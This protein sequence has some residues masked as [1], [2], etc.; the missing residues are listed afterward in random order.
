MERPAP[1][2]GIAGTS[3]AEHLRRLTQTLADV[4]NQLASPEA[5]A[6]PKRL[7]ELGRQHNDLRETIETARLLVSAESR[8]AQALEML[9]NEGDAELRELAEADRGEAAADAERLTRRLQSRLLP[10]DPYD[11]RGIMLEIRAGTG[12]EEA[13]LF[14]ADL[15]R[16]YMRFFEARGWAVEPVSQTD[17]EMGGF[18]E[19]IVNI[20]TPGA[21]SWLKFEG[22]TH[23][24]QRVPA[25]ETQGRI[26][27][28][29]A[30]VAVLPE[31]EETDVVIKDTD[32]RIDTMTSQG[33]GGQS[34]N[35]TYSAVRIVHLP[36]GMIVQC[37][38]ERS[39]LRN[40]ERAMQVLRARLMERQ[41]EADREA[42]SSMRKAMVGSGDRSQR[43]RTYNFPQNR[44]TDHRINLTLYNLD[45]VIQGQVDELFEALR[46]SETEERLAE[47]SS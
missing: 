44:V 42:R 37:Q 31:A 17:S 33:A 36:T 18:R 4:E 34:V 22:G 9:A 16:M 20:K 40:R 8:L 32:L 19:V 1:T 11:G 14:A 2:M 15:F 35:T 47:L 27:T 21:W 25:T 39:Q 6:S 29:A 23:R 10:P 24:V 7:A 43:I 5:A 28:S 30:T 46:Q 41:L 12:G 3:T 13:A 45:R 26:H 38:D